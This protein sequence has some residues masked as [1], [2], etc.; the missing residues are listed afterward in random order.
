MRFTD[1]RDAGRQL[2][3]RLSA[4]EGRRDVIVLALPRG[5]VPVAAEISRDLG[6][7]FDIFLVRKLGVPSHPELAMGA[8][9]EGGVEVLNH[10]LIRD[11]GVPSSAIHQVA[12]RERL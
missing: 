5:G 10:D 6:V 2:A 1:R 9:A 4:Y 3:E 7:P 8:I 12:V 11:I